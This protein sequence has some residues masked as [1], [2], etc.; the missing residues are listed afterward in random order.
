M[1][2]QKNINL[3]IN[4]GES[5]FSNEISVNFSPTNIFLDFK[6]IA[7]R[8][9]PR[10]QNGPTFS[11]KHNVI[12][13]DPYTLK[14]FSEMLEDVIG[15]YEKEFGKITKPKPI[16]KVEAQKKD[17]PAKTKSNIPAYFG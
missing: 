12:I 6:C 14:Q 11:M 15:R 17:M 7:P 9:D 1:E 5:F 3:S 2:E 13:L 10:N 8:V 4:D 16:E